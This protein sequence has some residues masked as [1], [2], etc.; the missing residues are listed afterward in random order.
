M[1]A[2]QA[3]LLKKPGCYQEVKTAVEGKGQR[4]SQDFCLGGGH[5]AGFSVVYGSR[6]DSVG[7]GGVVAEISRDLQTR[8]RFN[9]GGG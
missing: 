3:K 7:G 2:G 8:T 4:R 6:P 1:R 5:P 9:G